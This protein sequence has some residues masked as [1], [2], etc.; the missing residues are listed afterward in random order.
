MQPVVTQGTDRIVKTISALAPVAVNTIILAAQAGVVYRV[1][2]CHVSM[3]ANG[4]YA[5]YHGASISAPKVIQQGF[6]L[7]NIPDNTPDGDWATQ[8]GIANETV[9]VDVTGGNARIVL[10][11]I[12]IKVLG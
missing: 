3:D 12:E 5:V 11:Y 2:G 9:R 8:A 6:L 4:S 1:V 7:A 10:K